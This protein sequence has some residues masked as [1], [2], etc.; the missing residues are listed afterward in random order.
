MNQTWTRSLLKENAKRA[1]KKNYWVCVGVTLILTL[2]GGGVGSLG[3]SGS[4]FSY[5]RNVVT[6]NHDT[7]P[8]DDDSYVDGTS[9]GSSYDSAGL[10][11]L[12]AMLAIMAVVLALVVAVAFVLTVFVFNVIEVGGCMFFI[13]NRSCTPLAGTVFNGF[14]KGRYGNIVKT[15]F[16]RDLYV[17][18]WTLLFLVPGIVKS[19]EYLMVPYI[20]AENPSMDRRD[21]FALSKRMMDGEKW[22][23]FV[24]SLSF[25]GWIFLSSLTCGLVGVFYVNPY[26]M[27]TFTELYAFNKIKAYNEGYIR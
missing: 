5:E 20:L 25:L 22:N 13:Q 17:F 3:S 26:Y 15:M 4:V 2:F 11:V 10:A 8:Y 7:E 16:F 9:G 1:F 24:L 12:K 23:A 27:A 19:Y 21:A 14:R 6:D 18:L